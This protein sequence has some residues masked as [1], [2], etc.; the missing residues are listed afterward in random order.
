MSIQMD[1]FYNERE[2]F[3][4]IDTAIGDTAIDICKRYNSVVKK[5]NAVRDKTEFLNDR[6]I[7]LD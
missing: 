1:Y 6:K 3:D 4:N 5:D 2:R 7:E